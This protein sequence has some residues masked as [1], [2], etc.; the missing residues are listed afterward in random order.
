MITVTIDTW[1]LEKALEDMK[2]TPAQVDA[3]FQRVA[4]RVA[5]LVADTAKRYAPKGATQQEKTFSSKLKMWSRGWS[6]ARV[7]HVL[8]AAKKRRKKN[9]KSRPMGGAL[10]NSITFFAQPNV[11]EI[12]VPSN[13]P[14]GKYAVRIHDER[15]VTWK[16]RG[17]GT[18]MKGPQAREKFIERAMNDNV[19]NGKIDLIVADVIDK[20]LLK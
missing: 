13:S 10:Q 16:N 2:K 19:M 1:G 20:V 18:I 5:A 15:Y 11:A 7:S 4:Y 17:F 3:A 12:Y 6:P 8:K 9:A 14:A